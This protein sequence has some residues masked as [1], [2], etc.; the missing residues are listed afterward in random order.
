MVWLSFGKNIHSCIGFSYCI[1]A[2]ICK[3]DG[4]WVHEGIWGQASMWH[5]LGQVGI[6]CHSRLWSAWPSMGI[7]HGPIGSYLWH[8]RH[9]ESL[10]S[11][12]DFITVAI[13]V[14]SN[15]GYINLLA[16]LTSF[17]VLVASLFPGGLFHLWLGD[18]TAPAVGFPVASVSTSHTCGVFGEPG[19]SA[20][21]LSLDAFSTCVG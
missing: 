14:L 19:G 6:G 9:V 2:D 10:S 18:T 8:A 17:F 15:I 3:G 11:N 13:I 12:A 7:S 21:F 4:P 16:F 5:N 1:Y 20:R